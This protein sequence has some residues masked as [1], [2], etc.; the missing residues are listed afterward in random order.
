M[1]VY[2]SAMTTLSNRPDMRKSHRWLFV[3]GFSILLHLV[4]VGRATDLLKLPSPTIPAADVVTAALLA[5]PKPSAPPKSVAKPKTKKTPRSHPA[6]PKVEPPPAAAASAAA[7]TPVTEPATTEDTISSADTNEI[8]GTEGTESAVAPHYVIDLPPSVELK[9]DVQKT[10]K[11][12]QPTYG[13]GTIAWHS[14][15][16]RYSIDGEFGVLFITALHFKSSGTTDDGGIVPE[17][18]S[19]KR[20]RRAETNTHFHRERNTIS[21]SASTKLYPRSG[22][23][24]DRASIIWQLAGIGRGDSARFVP[25]AVFEI[26]VAGTRDAEPWQIQTIGFEEIIIDG[27]TIGAWHVV[28]APRAR[29]YDQKLDIWLAPQLQWY[30]VRLRY[31][32]PNGDYLD[33]SLTGLNVSA[34][35]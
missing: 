27:K 26:V 31:T 33:M 21:F 18:Y 19:E 25:G 20:F 24:Q 4:V 35:P 17:L 5:P 34:V 6:P 12:G 32:E 1:L 22:G 13:N 10:P 28:R 16:S 8:S 2:T 15:G 23:E 30:P 29:T 9:Y 14:D 3:L 7:N 11:E